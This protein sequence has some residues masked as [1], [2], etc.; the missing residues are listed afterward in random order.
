MDFGDNDA[1]SKKASSENYQVDVM[2]DRYYIRKK[3]I[4]KDVLMITICD[5]ES[6]TTGSDASTFNIGQLDI[7]FYDFQSNFKEI[8]GKIDEIS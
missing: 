3:E 6:D 7:M 1:A 2:Y 5:T 8:E 4:A